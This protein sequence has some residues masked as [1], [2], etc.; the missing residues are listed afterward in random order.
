MAIL[1]FCLICGHG[2]QCGHLHILMNLVLECLPA[3]S[4][5]A[6]SQWQDRD[7]NETTTG[8]RTNTRTY[9]L[10]LIIRPTVQC[11]KCQSAFLSF[12]LV[13]QC[14][15]AINM[16]EGVT[17]GMKVNS[18]PLLPHTVFKFITSLFTG[19]MCCVQI[20]EGKQIP[21]VYLQASSCIFSQRQSF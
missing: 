17:A 12:W 8:I 13:S 1:S 9:C 18:V 15:G 21:V 19:W 14:L 2:G 4:L 5:Q 6:T 20:M 16:I 7:G 11:G 3:F 10:L